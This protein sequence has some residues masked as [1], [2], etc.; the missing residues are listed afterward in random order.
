MGESNAHP[1][2]R[3]TRRT[4]MLHKLLIVAVAMMVLAAG[5]GL[6]LAQ[7]TSAKPHPEIGLFFSATAQD[8]AEGDAALEEIAAG[9]RDGYAG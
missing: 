3:R 9:W 1:L 7:P 5:T 6:G 4:V 8:D 2:D